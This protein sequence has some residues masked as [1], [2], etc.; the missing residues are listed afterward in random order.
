MATTYN[1]TNGSIDGQTV[2]RVKT[3]E[4]NEVF[5]LRNIVDF[6]KQT[7]EA[8]AADVAQVINIPA[9]TT[10]ITAWL[11][12]ITAETT[13]GTVDLGYGA[14]PDIWGDALAV[15]TTA[16]GIVGYLW[17]PY[18]FSAA[19]TIDLLATTD[20]ADIDIDG[21][22]VEVVAMCVKNVGAF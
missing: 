5:F 19:D 18:Y 16:G 15:D 11:R 2:P 4:E 20:T 17:V 21:L 3:A 8:G 6:S 1:F 9:D 14:N 12:I 10:V 13:N 22:K 7:I